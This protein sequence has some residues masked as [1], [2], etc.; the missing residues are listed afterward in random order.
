MMACFYAYFLLFRWRPSMFGAIPIGFFL[1][2]LFQIL[3]RLLVYWELDE[4][5][6]R[7]QSFRTTREIALA[8]VTH[9]G[10]LVPGKPSSACLRVDYARPAPMSEQGYILATPKDRVRFIAALRRFAPQATFEV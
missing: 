4:S 7:V 9:V 6:L 3:S 10:G 8:E 1:L 5:S 2:A